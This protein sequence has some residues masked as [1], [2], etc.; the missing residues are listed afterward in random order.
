MLLVPGAQIIDNLRLGGGIQRRQRFIQQKYC[1]IDHQGAGQCDSLS[2]PTRN[3]PGLA[4][5]QMRDAERLQNGS[6]A[7][8]A[9][10]SDQPGETVLNVALGRQMG[11]QRQVLKHVTNPPEPGRDINSERTVEQD[12]LLCRDSACVRPDQP[13]YAVEQSGL[14]CPGRTKQD[15]DSRRK[16]A[17]EIEF[18]LLSQPLANLHGRFVEFCRSSLD[19]SGA[20]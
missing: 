14:P 18:E 12:L 4:P 17:S 20:I 6:A 15:R 16:D 19:D 9:L 1:G 5:A 8:L 7:L 2:L 10:L 13:G 11:K 3:L